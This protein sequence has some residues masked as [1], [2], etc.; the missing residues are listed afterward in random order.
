MHINY[1]GDIL[2]V[3][4]L[5]IL[6]RNYY[7]SIVPILLFV[8]FVFYNI[9]MLDKYL[10]TKYGKAFQEYQKKTKKLIPFIY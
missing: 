6:T 4:A 3:A 7:A 5:A 10:S 1:F 2:W 9:P 8:M